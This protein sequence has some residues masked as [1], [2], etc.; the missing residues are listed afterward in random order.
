[1]FY[2]AAPLMF[3]AYSSIWLSIIAKLPHTGIAEKEELP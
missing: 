1:M 2:A 3:F